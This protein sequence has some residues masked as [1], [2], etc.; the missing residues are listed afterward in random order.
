MRTKT[1]LAIRVS[2]RVL[3]LLGLTSATAAPA[4]G[5]ACAIIRRAVAA[6]EHNW[7]SARHYGFSVF[8]AHGR[9]PSGL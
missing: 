7:K 3:L 8:R 4:D 1:G 2:I 9:A 6:E 5:A